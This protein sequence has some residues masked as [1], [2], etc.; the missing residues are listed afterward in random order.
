M[1]LGTKFGRGI[2]IINTLASLF[3]QYLLL[4][5]VFLAMFIVSALLIF[6]IK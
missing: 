2:V 5:A 3:F 6:D 4:L 1:Q